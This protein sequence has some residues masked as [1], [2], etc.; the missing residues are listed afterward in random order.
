MKP[1]ALK[2]T[3]FGPYAKQTTL[4]FKEDLVNQ[5]IFV[6][7]GP[8]GAGKTT[9]FDAICYAL[10]GETSGGSRTGKELRSD[11]A[12]QSEIKTEVE[13]TFQVKDKIYKILRAPQQQQKKKRGEGFREVPA[14]VE[15]LEVG[16]EEPPVTKE[17]EVREL[18][19]QIIGLKVEQFRKIVMIPQGDF[20][21]FLYANTT[22]KEEILRKIFGTDFYKKIQEQLTTKSNALKLEVADTQ[23]AILAEL[24]L[25]KT[26]EEHTIDYEQPLPTLLEVVKSVQKKWGESLETLSGMIQF[27]GESIQEH[28]MSYEAGK[29][30]NEKFNQYEQTLKTVDQ[31]KHYER[32]IKDQEQQIQVIKFAQSIIPS[33]NEMLKYEAFKR[34]ADLKKQQLQQSL[35][36][37]NHQFILVKKCYDAIESLREQLVGLNQQELELNRFVDGVMKLEE[38]ECLI[39]TLIVEG[40]VLKD[41]VEEKQKKLAELKQKVSLLDELSPQLTDLNE[42]LQALSFEKE[43][44]EETIQQLQRLILVVTSKEQTQQ[45]LDQLQ[46][47]YTHVKNESEAKREFYEH[48]A[49]LF[50]NAAAIRLANELQVNQACPVCGSKEHPNPRRSEEHILTK[51]EL[52]QE[53][54]QVEA[55][56][57]KSHHI[58]QELTALQMKK[59]QEDESIAQF[60]EWLKQRL[61]QEEVM[62]V[63]RLRLEQLRDQLMISFNDLSQLQQ[64]LNEESQ[65]ITEQIKQLTSEKENIHPLEEELLKEERLLQEKRECYSV[66]KR[67][68]ED[69]ELTIPMEYRVLTVLKQRISEISDQKI[70]LQQNI[71]QSQLDYE[72]VTHQLTELQAK[73]SEAQEQFV[74]YEEQHQM[75]SQTFKNQVEGSFTSL[76]HYEEAKQMI[77]QLVQLEQQ[78]QTFYQELH[79]ATKMVDL[80]KGELQG[81]DRVNISVIEEILADLESRKNQLTKEQATLLANLEQN[82]YLLNSI[83][84][85][86][87]TIQKREQEYLVIGELESLA[88]GRSG[89]KMSFETYVLSSYF[90]EVLEAA[91]TRLQKMTARRYYLLRREEVKGGGRKGLDLD[92]YDSHTAKT[93]PVNTLSGGESF[94]ASL[95]LALGLSDTVQQNSG[96]I[97]LDTMFIDE[98]FGTLDSESLDQAIDILMELQDHGRLI[99]V[100]SHVH[101][102]K[103][104]IPAKLVVEM[105]NRGSHAYFKM[106]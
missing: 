61:S 47:D 49:E 80:L 50:I 46:L 8:T 36:E 105:D 32:V 37:T 87:E 92:V 11:F 60:I 76:S 52:E 31:L 56:E 30:L 85:K 55:L 95:A 24:K 82:D 17:N 69:L 25:I 79:T 44:Q 72:R 62:E 3:A 51:Q 67:S 102:L 42:Q 15:L 88:N 99:G 27:L 106:S 4:N 93:R 13:F 40:N 64:T 66:E 28:R 90:D 89:G 16:G 5:E 14:S 103:E 2:L 48:Q 53:R 34:D 83:Q 18:I 20:K 26:D 73:L 43:K 9:I 101:E 35:E 100:I 10:Y 6:V 45:R 68:K 98:G 96:G 70:K 84:K 77:D 63:S 65:R 59:S 91:N 78:V 38:K 19:Q 54:A 23:K 58:N 29:H 12:A 7:T 74:H 39:Q 75:I 104:R 33:E 71:T 21:E 57:S 1:L 81:K 97:Q 41:Q 22:N 94:K 86:Y